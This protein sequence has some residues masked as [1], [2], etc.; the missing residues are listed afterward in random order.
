MAY[1]NQRK[2]PAP[3]VNTV[4]WTC[5]NDDCSGWMREDYSFDK[6]PHCPLCQSEMV[7]EEKTLP[8]ID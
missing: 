2:E 5:T 6:E 7:K 8:K 3:E 4:V 1:N